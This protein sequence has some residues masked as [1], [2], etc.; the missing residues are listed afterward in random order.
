MQNGKKI[1]NIKKM[2][3]KTEGFWTQSFKVLAYN[4]NLQ[5]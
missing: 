3:N 1:K 5:K 2:E 4:D